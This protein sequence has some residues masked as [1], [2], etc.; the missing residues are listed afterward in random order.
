MH[1]L[2]CM[3]KPSIFF[4]LWDLKFSSCLI[5]QWG[6]LIK[7][8]KP[9]GA[10]LP[11]CSW[12][13]SVRRV[14]CSEKYSL[15]WPRRIWKDLRYAEIVWRDR[16]GTDP[17]QSLCCSQE[18]CWQSLCCTWASNPAIVT[19]IPLQ[20]TVNLSSRNSRMY[21]DWKVKWIPKPQS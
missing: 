19:Q 5:L 13:G 18:I 11:V 12:I 17:Q 3:K 20:S 15:C 9:G 2:Y 8:W 14:N 16:M 7:E 6:S 1:C 4:M 10:G 21:R